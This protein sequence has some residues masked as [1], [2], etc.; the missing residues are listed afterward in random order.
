MSAVEVKF[1]ARVEPFGVGCARHGKG[2]WSVCASC[3]L[4][5]LDG[6]AQV[7]DS[8]QLR[9]EA[10]RVFSALG[11]LLN[12]G[13]DSPFASSVKQPTG[14]IVAGHTLPEV[15][16][17][18]N[19]AKT[20]GWSPGRV[21]P[22]RMTLDEA[23]FRS[24]VARLGRALHRNA[25][26]ARSADMHDLIAGA[27]RDLGVDV[28][29]LVSLVA[30]REAAASGH[31]AADDAIARVLGG[32]PTAPTHIGERPVGSGVGDELERASASLDAAAMRANDV[33]GEAAQR[34]ARRWLWQR[35][36]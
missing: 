25:E 8:P 3:V 23:G 27:L 28:S 21:A 22:D 7:G 34:P 30:E 26:G 29:A 36:T 4:E 19:Y 31:A 16:E 6:I 35:R 1:G 15:L 10:H 2:T 13:V 12:G 14:S 5:A 18:L 32:R 17:A 20:H 9:A 11:A 33:G 24:A